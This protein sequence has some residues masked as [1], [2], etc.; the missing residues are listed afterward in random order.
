[1]AGVKRSG[2]REE[3]AANITPLADVTTTLIVVFLIT[4][5][6]I[7][8][9]GIQVNATRAEGSETVVTTREQQDEEM[10]MVSVAPEGIKVNGVTVT[11]EE[12]EPL[13]AERLAERIDKTV[14][15]VPSD[16]VHLGEV[17]DVMDAAKGGGATSLALLNRKEGGN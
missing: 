13:L 17:V 2:M 9:N 10:L 8:G 14:V 11:L 7:M 15:I 1:M 5:P 3:N 4:M 6:A 16:F 12:L